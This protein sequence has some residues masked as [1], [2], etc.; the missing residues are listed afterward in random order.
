MSVDC[1]VTSLEKTILLYPCVYEPAAGDLQ[2]ISFSSGQVYFKTSSSAP[3]LRKIKYKYL[4][5]P[6]V[7]R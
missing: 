3:N 7:F 6:K 1:R 4:T 2:Q 5:R